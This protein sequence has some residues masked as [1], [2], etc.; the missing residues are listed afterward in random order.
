[1]TL[2]TE[3]QILIKREFDAPKHLVFKAWT[4]PGPFRY[5]GKHFHYRVIDPWVLPIQKP[6]PPFWIPGLVSPDTVLWCAKKRYPYIALATQL[7]PTVEMWKLY[8]EQA[9]RE[10]QQDNREPSGD[11]LLDIGVQEPHRFGDQPKMMKALLSEA[12]QHRKH[13]E[14][15]Q[16]LTYTP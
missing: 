3:E 1:M 5:E 10:E 11:T 6:H 4:T 2:P 16:K 7:A 14:E 13:G 8:T 9:A 12:D 15:Q